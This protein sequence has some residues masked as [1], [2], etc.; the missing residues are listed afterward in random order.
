M[1]TTTTI[2]HG[3]TVSVDNQSYLRLPAGSALRRNLTIQADSA[4][5][6]GTVQYY[7]SRCGIPNVNALYGALRYDYLYCTSVTACSR[8][9]S[10]FSDPDDPCDVFIRVV[11]SSPSL[12][13]SFDVRSVYE[14]PLPFVNITR[15]VPF[16]ID[17]AVNNSSEVNIPSGQYNGFWVP[18]ARFIATDFNDD[19]TPSVIAV[20]EGFHDGVRMCA[21]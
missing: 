13:L 18:I 1:F 21:L 9:I 16:I 2:T 4:G 3:S 10:V 20:T 6:T 14:S 8:S 15:K 19:T 17:T 7:V 11:Y 12:I 5:V